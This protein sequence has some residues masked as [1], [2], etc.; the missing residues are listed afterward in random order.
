MPPST[1]MKTHERAVRAG[2][3]IARI[4]AEIQCEI[5]RVVREGQT[6]ILEGGLVPT[7]V[8]RT[9]RGALL[10]GNAIVGIMVPSSSVWHSALLASGT[11]TCMR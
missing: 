5:D 10:E 9:Q 6:L 3:A 8:T 11:R 4:V 7:P 1:S 2:Y